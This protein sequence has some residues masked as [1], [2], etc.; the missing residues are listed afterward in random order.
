MFCTVDIT[1]A[2]MKELS[3]DNGPNGIV[4]PHRPVKNARG[5]AE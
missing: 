4:T 2:V 3:L 1:P 5:N